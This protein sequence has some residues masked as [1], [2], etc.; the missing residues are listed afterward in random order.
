[1]GHNTRKRLPPKSF[2]RW[3][4]LIGVI[5]ILGAWTVTT[6]A[7]DEPLVVGLYE[8]PPFV[9]AVDE[10]TWDGLSVQL[11]REIADELAL[12]Y[13]FRAVP[14]EQQVQGLVDGSLDVAINTI[15]S[16]ETEAEIDYSQ[17]YYTTELGAA[18]RLEQTPVDVIRAVVSP[19]FLSTA[20]WIVVL[21]AVVG[22]LIWFLEGRHDTDL[23]GDKM[24]HGVWTGF[25]WAA[26]TMSTT[27]YGDIV[28]KSTA[29]RALA[30]I[31]M[32]LAMVITASLT[33]TITTVLTRTSGFQPVTFPEGLQEN[34]VG[35]VEGSLGAQLLDE[36]NI[37]YH[38]Y[39]TATDGMQALRNQEIDVFV[40]NMASLRYVRNQAISPLQDIN[41]QSTG[42]LPQ[43]YAF[44]LPQN[45]SLREPINRLILRRINNA[46]W[47]DVLSRYMPEE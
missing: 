11:W 39:A 9:I 7:Q 18:E 34:T 2:R 15:A 37:D 5:A 13:E 1:M 32:L 42:R 28:P 20:L 14:R 26:V 21:L 40:D 33:A 29:G 31:W 16:G 23:Y 35:A 24:H 44:A 41:I 38:A 25:W 10:R 19:E 47:H 46:Q 6:H 27:G 4:W 8:D 30:L 12:V 22:A 3:V 43:L 17:V 45:G 36:E